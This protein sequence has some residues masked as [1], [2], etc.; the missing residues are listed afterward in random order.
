MKRRDDL[1]IE[2][3]RDELDRGL[4]AERRWTLTAPTGSGK[5]TRLPLWMADGIVP[6]DRQIWVIQP[7][8]L[9]ARLLAARMAAERGEPMGGEVGFQVR[10]ESVLSRRTRIVYM[11]DGVALR[12]LLEEEREIP[13]GALLFDEFHE[14]RLESD[15]A[16]SLAVRLQKRARPDLS[17]GVLSATLEESV[18][19]RFWP[20]APFWRV[21]GRA[22][23]VEVRFRGRPVPSA[24]SSWEAAAE[25]LIEVWETYCEGHALVFLPGAVEISRAVKRLSGHP[26]LTGVEILPLHGELPV[27]CQLRALAPSGRRKVIVATNVAETSLTIEGIR[28]VVDSGWARKSRYDP[29]RGV[30]TLDVEPISQFSADQRAGRAGRTAPGVCLRLWTAEEHARRP[31][32]ETPEIH[33]LDLSEL[34]LMARLAGLDPLKD[35]E[36]LDPPLPASLEQGTSLLQALGALD[37]D[38][39]LTEIGRRMGR[40]P[41]HPRWARLMVEAERSVCRRPAVWAAALAEHRL[42]I[43]RAFGA[44]S[45]DVTVRSLPAG[46]ESDFPA[47]IRL[48]R[49]VRAAN[50]NPEV[51]RRIGVNGAAAREAGE[52]ARR[53]LALAEE[54]IGTR[55]DPP[56]PLETDSEAMARCLLAAFP[57]RVARRVRPGGREFQ[58]VRGISALLDRSSAVG[59]AAWVVAAEVRPV[60][61]GG[62]PGGVCMSLVTAIEPTWLAEAHP[63]AVTREGRWGW[64]ERARRVVWE[65]ERRYYDLVW[66]SVRRPAAASPEAS[67]VLVRELLRRRLWPEG[68]REAFEQWSGRLRV[69]ATL[70]PEEGFRVPTEADW[71]EGLRRLC[72]GAVSYQEVQER[73]YRSMWDTFLTPAQRRRLDRLAPEWIE[74]PGGRRAAVHYPLTGDPFVAVRIQDLYGVEEAPRVAKGR[75]NLL[76]HILAPNQRPVQITRDLA[77][78]WRERY[79]VVRREL[80]RRYPRHEWR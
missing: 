58:M 33:R 34:V 39:A 74:L 69:V 57:D 44:P 72:E 17:I 37:R 25:A 3:A 31:A 68:T 23:P 1:P 29:V 2:A 64:E 63:L 79:P 21:E 65:E 78:F 61:A 45:E 4:R 11:T 19:R 60:E 42:R 62:P 77:G 8:R 12:R 24:V 75:L 40:Y 55:Q 59:H 56:E 13:A 38:G 49:E 76:V 71:E 80:Q 30:N 36:W 50:F 41:V 73:S 7:R 46:V 15:M 6:S 22:W 48:W 27:D 35:L 51:C 53:Y 67:E 70:C 16:L 66:A 32:A 14:R 5:S 28:L 9:A 26:L 10:F 20:G 54:G 43:P 52:V 47:L 18:F